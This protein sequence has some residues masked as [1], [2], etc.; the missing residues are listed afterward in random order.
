[1]HSK[2]F[3][4]LDAS[5]PKFEKNLLT[6]GGPTKKKSSKITFLSIKSPNSSRTTVKKIGSHDQLLTFQQLFFDSLVEV[7]FFFNA[8][9]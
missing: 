2:K 4:N 3:D 1:L 6:D 8:L 7:R 5:T 9:Q